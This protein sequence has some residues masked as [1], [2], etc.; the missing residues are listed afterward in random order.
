MRNADPAFSSPD[1]QVLSP[2]TSTPKPN[3]LSVVLQVVEG[4][5]PGSVVG[6]VNQGRPE[7]AVP[8]GR[9]TYLVVGGTDGD[10]TFM[11]DRLKGD[12]YLVHE[13]DYEKASEYTLHVEVSDFSRAFPGSHLVE[14]RV[15]VQDSNDH[16]PR[17]TEDPVTIV[18]P[19]NLQ[20]GASIYTFR[21]VDEVLKR[22]VT[23][24]SLTHSCEQLGLVRTSSPAHTH[25]LFHHC[26]CDVRTLMVN[27]AL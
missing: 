3:V 24:L 1:P 23:P 25:T 11:V 10:G 26:L 9:V 19:E 4:T 15:E 14:L 27:E 5:P 8:D 12:V 21:A 20:P 6:S 22:K 13:L 2:A 16:R 7:S 17:F 18:V